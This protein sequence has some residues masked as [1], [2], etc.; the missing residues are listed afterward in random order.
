MYKQVVELLEEAAI[1]YTQYTHEPILDYETDR[2][3]RERFKLEG[4][5][6]K[7][8]FLKDKSNN[9]YIFVT[10]EGEKLDSKLMKDLVGKKISICSA[11]ELIEKTSCVPGCVSPFGYSD[12]ITLIIDRKIYNYNKFL[13]SPGIPEITIEIPTKS[14]NK[15]LNIVENNI[16]IYEKRS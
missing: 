6:S 8:L 3:I 5:P 7:N 13:L 15:I 11:E 12:E 10:V 14:I 4:V 9:Y 2:K 1:S 16:L